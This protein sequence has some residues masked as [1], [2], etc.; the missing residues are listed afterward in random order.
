MTG[1]L[2]E[3]LKSLMEPEAV[4]GLEPV[5]D[6]APE[7]DAPALPTWIVNE[8]SSNVRERATTDSR[9]V[10]VVRRGMVLTEIG[11]DGNWIQIRIPGE[12]VE[13]WIHSRMLMEQPTQV[14]Q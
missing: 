13:G 2:D 3:T 12:T 4:S 1:A 8:P 10:G 7:P 14:G 5:A 9:V 11:R 6:V